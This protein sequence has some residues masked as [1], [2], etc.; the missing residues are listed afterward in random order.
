LKREARSH[1][2]DRDTLEQRA[3]TEYAA[4][5]LHRVDKEP[6]ATGQKQGLTDLARRP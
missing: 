2:Q 6:A 1:N 5:G 4:S 3:G